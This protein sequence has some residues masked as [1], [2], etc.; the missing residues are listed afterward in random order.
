MHKLVQN[1]ILLIL[2][3]ISLLPSYNVAYNVL[4]FGAKPNGQSDSS[5]A[6]RRAWSAAC[7][8]IKPATLDV[9][10]GRYLLKPVTF[11]GPCRN[12]ISI[13]IDGTLLAPNDYWSM[14]TSGFWILFH[15]VSR[16][17]IRGG[18]LDGRG[19]AFWQCRRTGRNCPPGARVNY[20]LFCCSFFSFCFSNFRK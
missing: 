14:G 2:C 3:I 6:F 13:N 20:F 19:A 12:R 4:Q 11:T 8:S 18:T 17:S 10:G 1:F 16:V 9:P 15:Q 5:L 7:S